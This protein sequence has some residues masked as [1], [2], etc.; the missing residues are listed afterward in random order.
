MTHEKRT[1]LRDR[2]NKIDA[3]ASKIGQRAAQRYL[4][5]HESPNSGNI[6]EWIAGALFAALMVALAVILLAL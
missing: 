4:D 2:Q 6:R 3:H 5:T 1:A